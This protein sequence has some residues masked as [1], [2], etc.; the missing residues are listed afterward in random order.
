MLKTI[1]EYL[2][3]PIIASLFLPV[4]YMDQNCKL[5]FVAV[6]FQCIYSFPLRNKFILDAQPS[7]YPPPHLFSH[8]VK[9]LHHRHKLDKL[10]LKESLLFLDKQISQLFSVPKFFIQLKLVLSEDVFIVTHDSLNF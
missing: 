7:L 1:F 2:Y 10:L 5:A 9:S 6:I 3:R 8:E 4:D